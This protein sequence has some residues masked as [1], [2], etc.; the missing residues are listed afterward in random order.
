MID[1]YRKSWEKR[2]D[3]FGLDKEKLCEG[4][5]SVPNAEILG[6]D[7]IAYENKNG[8]NFKS[9]LAINLLQLSIFITQN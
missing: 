3:R 8:K 6:A 1:E 7:A 9:R 5:I 2:I 4:E